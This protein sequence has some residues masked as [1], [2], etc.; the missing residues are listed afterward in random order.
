MSLDPRHPSTESV[1][2]HC[3]DLLFLS[4][5]KEGRE[6]ATAEKLENALTETGPKTLAERLLG[7]YTQI[8]SASR[9]R[10]S[11]MCIAST[12]HLRA[13]DGTKSR[14]KSLISEN[15]SIY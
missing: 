2:E 4:M 5:E 8:N 12:I 15:F 13:A 3:I 14:V 6:E 1:K 10:R 7:M 11:R 9:A